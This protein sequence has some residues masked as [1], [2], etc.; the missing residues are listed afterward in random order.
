MNQVMKQQNP[1]QSSQ[2]PAPYP[3]NTADSIR[4]SYF[5]WEFKNQNKIDYPQNRA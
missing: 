1:S 4:V 5:T 2:F 3:D